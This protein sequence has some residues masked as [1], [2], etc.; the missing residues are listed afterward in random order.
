[1]HQALKLGVL[2]KCGIVSNNA[3]SDFEL[4]TCYSEADPLAMDNT[5]CYF[6]CASA[7]STCILVLLL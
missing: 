3:T 7:V 1:M 5:L 6:V 2:T 4:I